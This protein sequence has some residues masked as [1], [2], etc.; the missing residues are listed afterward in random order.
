LIRGLSGARTVSISWGRYALSAGFV[1]LAA[2]ARLGGQPITC[3][4][5]MDP[6]PRGE[7]DCGSMQHGARHAAVIC[8]RRLD[9]VSHVLTS[10][11]QAFR[12]PETSVSTRMCL[13]KGGVLESA[14]GTRT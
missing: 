7:R 5:P 13:M 8:D 14:T 6:A 3:D 11:G 1:V 9:F 2:G 4:G 10:G 12:R